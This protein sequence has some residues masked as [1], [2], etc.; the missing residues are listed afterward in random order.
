MV[1]NGIAYILLLLSLQRQCRCQYSKE[2]KRL[3]REAGHTNAIK[4]LVLDLR[5]N[6]GAYFVEAVT[7]AIFSFPKCRGGLYQRKGKKTNQSFKTQ[8]IPYDLDIPVPYS[9]IKVCFCQ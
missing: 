3:K 5:Y 7:F 2:L 4:G 6:G 8:A 9:S 1:S